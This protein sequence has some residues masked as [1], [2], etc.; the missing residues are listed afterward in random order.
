MKRLQILPALDCR[1][2]DELQRIVAAVDECDS[3]VGY[4]I[5]FSLGLTYGLPV[6]VKAVRSISKKP[7]IYDHQKAATDIPDT[8]ELF[9]KTM[10]NARI[11][12]AILFPQ[13]GPVTLRAWIKALQ[14]ENVHVIVGGLM[15]HDGYTQSQGG[16][17]NDD[18]I[19]SIYRI[20]LEEGVSSFVVPLTKPDATKKLF[21]RLQFNA[22][23][24][25]YS[26]GFGAQGGD[27][28]NFS[29][30]DDH[31]VI[32]GRSLCAAADPLAYLR[33]IEQSWNG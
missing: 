14:A 32:I 23:H 22:S 5:G 19:E 17:I 1:T 21:E 29:F 16:Y 2:S 13:A 4:K 11:N 27:A 24:T 7:I 8:G 18:A 3:V 30:I 20:A 10:S 6:C 31:V 25:F 15:T 12:S 33:S 28:K 26:P 9:A